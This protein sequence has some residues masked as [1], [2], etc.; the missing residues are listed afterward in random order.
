MSSVASATWCMPGPAPRE[1]APDRGVLARRRQQLD[2]TLA[3]PQRDGVDALGLQRVP[4]LDAGAEQALPGL[5]RL[6]EIGDRDPE[7][8][9]AADVHPRD[10]GA[11][12]RMGRTRTVPTVSDDR[13]SALTSES[14]ASSSARSSVSRSS[15]ASATRSSG[16]RCLR[17]RRSASS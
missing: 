11:Q 17:S 5:D 16:A 12:S 8:M 14:S 6:V 4:V 2:A 10:A 9:D 13:D 7:V 1:K 3:H 15:S